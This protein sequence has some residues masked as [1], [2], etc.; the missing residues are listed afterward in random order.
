MKFEFI[1]DLVIT[2]TNGYNFNFQERG[3]ITNK[4]F[5]DAKGIGYVSKRLLSFMD[6]S[7]RQQIAYK[8]T[9]AEVHNL[10]AMF[11]HDFR[12]LE[13]KDLYAWRSGMFKPYDFELD[14]AVKVR[15]ATSSAEDYTS[16]SYMGEVRYNYEEKYFATANGS[17]YGSSNFAPGHQ[18]GLFWSVGAAWNIHRE[19]FMASTKKWLSSLKVRANFGTSGNDQIGSYRYTDMYKIVNSNDQPSINFVRKGNP[20][21]TWETVYKANLGVDLE[22]KKGKLYV[23]ADLYNNT[24]TNTL[25][26][27]SVAYSNGYNSIPVNDGKFRNYGLELMVKANLLKTRDIDLN[28]RITGSYSKALV[29]ENPKTVI[30]GKEV[31]LSLND[32]RAVGHFIGDIYGRHYMGVDP[33]TGFGQWEQWKDLNST[34]TPDAPVLDTYIYEHEKTVKNGN[35][36]NKRDVQWSKGNITNDPNKASRFFLGKNR[37]PDFFGGFGIDAS[38][39]GFDL[40]ASFEYIIGGYNY[41]D[42]YSNLMEDGVFGARNYHKDMLKAWTAENRNTTVPIML[43]GQAVAENAN[44]PEYNSTWSGAGDRFL[45]SNTALRFSNVRL[46][47]NFPHKVIEKIKLNSLS[48]WVRA[49]NLFVLSHRKGYDPFT[50]FGG[51]NERYQYTPLST[52]V[53]GLKFTF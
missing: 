15:D 10:D 19:L 34:T 8:K 17:V 24:V 21:L 53:G 23:E 39:Y 5:G 36:V 27:K 2:I 46:A 47:Y 40:S 44:H 51:G 49:D 7:S 3:D 1:K 42:I 20:D 31:E 28:F 4:Y 33:N 18:Y 45:T 6:F 29:L 30:Q 14:N 11:G 9:L 16:E 32:G 41:D 38:A 37:Y 25:A 52:F 43:A 35:I 48:L 12:T 13:S 22:L 50:Y 26:F